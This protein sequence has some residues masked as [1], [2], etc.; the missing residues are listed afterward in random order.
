MV[1]RFFPLFKTRQMTT[2]SDSELLAHRKSNYEPE[3]DNLYKIN[4][5]GLILLLLVNLFLVAL[6]FGL[7]V[8]A[9]PIKKDTERNDKNHV[10]HY[11][12][13]QG[14]GQCGIILVDLNDNPGINPAVV[15]GESFRTIEQAFVIRGKARTGDLGRI[16]AT[17]D[18]H[19]QGRVDHRLK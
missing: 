17:F 10:R 1:L 8:R 18:I 15:A 13:G 12:G 5:L 7:A 3:V 11:D 19:Q 16:T 6:A 14:G 2:N 4:L 9:I